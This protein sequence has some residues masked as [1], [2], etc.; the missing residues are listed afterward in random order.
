MRNPKTGKELDQAMEDR[1]ETAL[2]EYN[3]LIE[4]ECPSCHNH[5][6]CSTKIWECKDPLHQAIE[7]LG[8]GAAT[9]LQLGRCVRCGKLSGKWRWRE[10]VFEPGHIVYSQLKPEGPLEFCWPCQRD[11]FWEPSY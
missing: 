5:Y 3:Q 7:Q 11:S 2:S 9:G 6:G 4:V 1:L 10:M 8:L